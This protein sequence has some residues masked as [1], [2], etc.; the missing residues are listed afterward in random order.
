MPQ[1]ILN[2]LEINRGRI[3]LGLETR[4]RVRELRE[5][6]LFM[7]MSEIGRLVGIS[8]QRVFQILQEE[9]LPTKHL[10][11]QVNKHRY[12]CQVCGK[13]GSHAF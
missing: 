4:K 12:H 7:S 13:I 9:G 10:S 2:R 8:R 11:R 3:L 6:N 1:A 5:S